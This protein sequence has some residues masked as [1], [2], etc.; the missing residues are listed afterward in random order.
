MPYSPSSSAVQGRTRFWSSRRASTISAT[1][2]PGAYHADVPS[3]STISPPPLRVRS[4]IWSI[5]S[6]ETSRRSGIPPTLVADTTG[7][8]WSPWPPSTIAVTSFTD[9]PVAQAMNVEKRAVSRMPAIPKT[10]SFGRPDT[11]FATWHIAS[12]G[13]ETTIR[14]VTGHSRRS[15][16]P[17][18]DHDHVRPRGLLVAVRPDDVGLVAHD[19][20]HLV[21]VERLA[22]RQVLLDVDEDDIGVVAQRERLGARRAD[23]AGAD[24]GDLAPPAHTRT[25]SFSTIASATSLVPT[26]V[27]SSR[28]GFMS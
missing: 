25:P 6:S 2:A 26:A 11:F 15:R 9:E 13:L 22:L 4:T 20:A 1:A 27:G 21:D 12:R 19:R 14:I 28:D 18:R 8:I 17:G 23:V 3:R 24:D 10:P 7:T 5:R 16:Q